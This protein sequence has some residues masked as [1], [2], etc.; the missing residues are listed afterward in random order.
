MRRVIVILAAVLTIAAMVAF[1][2]HR[3]GPFRLA[4]LAGP[5]EVKQMAS[6]R[7]PPEKIVNRA[8]QEALAHVFYDATYRRIAYPG[9]DVPSD[10]GACTDVIIRSLRSAGYDLQK[11]IYEDKKCHPGAYPKCGGRLGCD[12]NIDHRRVPNQIVY[13]RSHGKSL[14]VSTAGEALKTWQPGD[15]VY[16][17][18]NSN[19]DHCGI[20]S[21][22]RNSAG[23]PLVIHNMAMAT[24]ED[25]LNSWQII[26]HIRFPKGTK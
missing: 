19:Q 1:V 18:L 6:P 16:W 4:A 13:F 22:N 17:K 5:S 24:E 10:R 7:T 12:P 25:C 20:I 9:G 11:L 21:D 3:P 8:K 2:P 26:C 23:M 14:P 15:L